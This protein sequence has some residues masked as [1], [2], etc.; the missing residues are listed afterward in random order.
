[1]VDREALH[2]A[3]YGVA[4]SQTWLSNWKTKLYVPNSSIILDDYMEK[5]TDINSLH[6][7]I[8]I[9]TLLCVYFR[10]NSEDKVNHESK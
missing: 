10:S 5:G 4:K 6:E 7:L 3:V 9:K 2:A 8:I 1:M